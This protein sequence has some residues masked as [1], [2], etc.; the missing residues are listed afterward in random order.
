VK[1]DVFEH[2]AFWP[3]LIVLLLSAD[4]RWFGAF[5]GAIL[6]GGRSAFRTAR[7]VIGSMSAGPTQMAIAAV[8][9]HA[10]ALPEAIAL[11]LLVGSVLIEFTAP[12]RRKMADQ[13]A[14]MEAQFESTGT[15]DKHG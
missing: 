14:E 2:F 3:L 10:W 13:L 7:M 8:A 11:A 4:G 9:V 5:F 15:T 6:P 12:T 1:I